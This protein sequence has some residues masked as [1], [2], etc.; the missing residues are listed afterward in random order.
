MVVALTVIDGVNCPTYL[1]ITSGHKYT[2]GPFVFSHAG[3]RH[4]R[5]TYDATVLMA[6]ALISFFVLI[7]FV[8]FSCRTRTNPPARSSTLRSSRGRTRERPL[9]P[10]KSSIF[11]TTST[12]IANC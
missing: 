4:I 2:A 6:S 1:P 8:R 9:A 10:P 3:T 12:S 11:S 5:E 7:F